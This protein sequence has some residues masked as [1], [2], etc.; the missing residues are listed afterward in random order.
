MPNCF[1]EISTEESMA[2]EFY[3][4]Q[5]EFEFSLTE[6]YSDVLEAESQQR[7]EDWEEAADYFNSLIDANPIYG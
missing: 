2:Y 3:C 7:A 1:E 6:D 5:V 4:M